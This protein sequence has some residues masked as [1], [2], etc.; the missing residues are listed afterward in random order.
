MS[1]KIRGKANKAP[2]KV[3][4]EKFDEDKLAQ[5]VIDLIF[6]MHDGFN[7]HKGKVPSE[8]NFIV[9][10]SVVVKVISRIRTRSNVSSNGET[11]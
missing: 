6:W 10:P 7:L 4:N 5:Y 9:S 8:G 1:V 11:T 3:I 2:I